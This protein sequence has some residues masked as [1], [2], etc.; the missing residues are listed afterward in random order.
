MTLPPPPLNTYLPTPNSRRPIGKKLVVL[1]GLRY[2]REVSVALL[3][4]TFALALETGPRPSQ[5]I[6]TIHEE[7]IV[8]ATLQETFAFFSDAMNLE[9]LTP[10]WL[11]FNVRTAPPLKMREGLEIDY[12]ISLHGLPIPWK[13]RI[14][15]WEPGVRFVD[16]QTAGPYLWWNHEHRFEQVAGGT[17]VVDH[18]EFV[19]RLRWITTGFVTRDVQKIFRY[20][21]QM[22]TRIFNGERQ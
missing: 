5:G 3:L 16:R 11:N 14:D 6:T 2:V 21:Q 1:T 12:V 10:G 20:R 4:D 7:T 15:V 22:L 13:T 17:K 19:P 18:V 8:P 9:K